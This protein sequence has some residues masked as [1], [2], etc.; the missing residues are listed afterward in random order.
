MAVT[1]VV[2]THTCQRRQDLP[3]KQQ[4]S[5]SLQWHVAAR[6]WLNGGTT[7]GVGPQEREPDGAN[8]ENQKHTEEPKPKRETPPG[9]GF[10]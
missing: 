1:M 5:Q 6:G 9:L 4:L 2:T 10:V 3:K 8:D 7:C